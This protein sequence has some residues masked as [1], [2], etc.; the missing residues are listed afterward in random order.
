MAD[1]VVEGVAQTSS[2]NRLQRPGIVWID[3]SIGYMV[4][5][6]SSSDIVYRK[7]VDGGV[8]WADP[9]E[10]SGQTTIDIDVWFDKWTPG[11]NGTIIH[12]VWFDNATDDVHYRALDTSGDSLGT[13]EVVHDGT[14]FES[15]GRFTHMLSITKAIGGNLYIQWW[16]DN[17]GEHGFSRSTDGGDNWTARTDGADGNA[18]DEVLCFP[19][20]DSA[21]TNDI[22]MIYWDRSADAISIKKY[23][24]SGG[25]S[26]TWAETAIAGG[27]ADTTL[28]LNWSAVMRHSDG[29]IIVAAWS[30]LDHVA[31]DLRVWD[32]EVG[33]PGSTA[34]TDVVTNSDD[35]FLVGMLIDQ[36]TDDLYVAYAGNEDGSEAIPTTVTVFYK[37]S[38]DGGATWSAQTAY[39]DD[40]A[41][42]DIRWLCG[43]QSTPG[44][45][46]GRWEPIWYNDDL[47]D[48]A[49]NKVN[50]VELAAGV[51]SIKTVNG[52]AKASVKT[53]NGLAI[54]NVKTWGGL[55]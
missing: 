21:D 19:D 47:V 55:A 20:A 4:F 27:V 52:L 24:D 28:Y 48:L 39:Q 22:V 51:S 35:C 53:V 23:D 33:T 26:G 31:A 54:A 16:G 6:N 8:T 44:A 14:S 36:N 25:A 37:K 30:A 3:S 29:H 17:D 10:I 41:P 34:K 38:D 40:T 50:S 32:V 5:L 2:M 11:D 49:V 45:A 43:G 1:V 9:V 42:D 13:A 46:A 18:V 7:T 12:I 15:T